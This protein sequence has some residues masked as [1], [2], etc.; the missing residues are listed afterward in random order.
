[1]NPVL[2]GRVT[3]DWGRIVVVPLFIGT[4]L[5]NL[6]VM[7]RALH[8]GSSELAIACSVLASAG[9]IAFQVLVILAY[10]RRGPATATTTSAS[11][12]VAA[13][14]AT[15]L[16]LLVLPW[17]GTGRN[18]QLDVAASVLIAMAMG[19]ALWSVT[20]LG[21]NISVFAQTRQLADRGPY[22]LVRHPLYLA[23]VIAVAGITLH[24]ARLA[25]VL[26]VP[27]MAALQA[28]RA[29]HEERLLVTT[30]PGYVEYRQR[31]AR[32]IPQVH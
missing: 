26:L 14:V 15:W 31:T 16:P 24:T 32:L 9:T 11:A 29:A 7:V 1:M 5:L 22:R 23:E 13:V 4:L 20:V 10:L 25:A 18:E 8:G 2:S 28:F 12:R 17:L 3:V 6:Q 19:L 21:T 27:L 30:L